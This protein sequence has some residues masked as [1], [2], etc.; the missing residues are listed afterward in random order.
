MMLMSGLFETWVL[1]CVEVF[2]CCWKYVVLWILLVSGGCRRLCV[3]LRSP[4]V[5]V[6][7]EGV[8]VGDVEVS[9]GCSRCSRKAICTYSTVIFS[10]T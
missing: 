6:D 7:M 9:I 4:E 1:C 3:M 8:V 5:V 2:W 10:R